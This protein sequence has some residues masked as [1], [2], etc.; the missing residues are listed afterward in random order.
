[1]TED[2][3]RNSAR[4]SRSKLRG[5]VDDE[6]RFHIEQLERDLIARGWRP[7]AAHAEAE[8]R[9]GSMSPIRD[10]CLTIDERRHRRAAWTDTMSA[11]SQDIRYVARTLRKTPAFSFIVTLT[12]ALGIGTATA[13]FSLV[14]GVILKPLPY[15]SPEN[16]VVLFDAQRDQ[17]ELPMS[18][19]EF[20]DW[21]D[22]STQV[23][24]GIGAWNTQGQ[25]L[26]GNGDAEQLLGVRMTAS[27]PELLGVTPLIGRSFRADE[28]PR[29]AAHVVM[30]GE[31]LWRRRFNADAAIVGRTI[32]LT[33]D[34]Y[35]VIGI[36][37]ATARAL[38]PSRW[39][40]GRGEPPDFWMP[41]GLDA[42]NS[43]AGLHN[44][45]VIGR[46]RPDIPLAQASARL[47]DLSEV[48]KKERGTTHGINVVSLTKNLVGNMREPLAL[49]LGAVGVLL[50]I[51]C[52]NVANLMLARAAVRRRELAVRSAL[53]AGR[54]RILILILAESVIRALIG[55]L[56]GTGLAYAMVAVARQS[57]VGIV[58][59]VSEV[60]VDGR[61]LLA[62]LSI[63]LTAGLLFGVVPAIRAA[64]GDLLQG[65]RDGGRGV[66]GSVSRDRI[67]RALIVAEVA[68]S[69]MLLAT[70]GLLT[71]S[72]VNLLSVPTGFDAHNVVV[73]RTWLPSSRYPD[74]LSQVAFW[75]RLSAALEQ[76]GASEVTTASD[77]PIA[78]GTSGDTPMEGTTYAPGE[79]PTAQKRIV[80]SNYFALLRAHIALGRGLQSTDVLGAPPVV[81]VNQ[82]F[83]NRYLNGENP[84]GR[85]A[86]FGWGIDGFQTIVGVVADVR[87]GALN[88]A[89]QPAIYISSEQRPSDFMNVLIRTTRSDA[90]VAVMFRRVLA[91]LDPQLPLM[92][93]RRMSDVMASTVRQQRLATMI[94]GA[95]ALAALVLAA[96][97]LYGVISYSVAQRS[98]E[99]GVRAALGAAR[100]DLMRLVLEQSLGFATAGIA[101][102][103]AG[104]IGAGRLLT[105][106][107]FGVGSSDPLVLGG[108]AAVLIVVAIVASARP[109]LLA[110]KANPLEALRSD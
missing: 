93:V 33:G 74:S 40:L 97:G 102:G 108:V 59:R 66:M 95:F 3:W 10:A 44:L 100:W 4:P 85:R 29:G 105:N 11:I 83:V 67:R 92:D 22:R 61:A 104:S 36:I 15:S 87:E 75:R 25:V 49:L 8:R 68:L 101:I 98:Q 89:P 43:P 64:G 82:A 71:R 80:G 13:I 47:G 76:N 79:E 39:L 41:L 6:L 81:M 52:A 73:G 99:L 27:I 58:P 53:G 14:D 20:L 32:T 23:L 31:R 12:L 7:D 24:S 19:P 17:R 88:G 63:S 16:L 72:F 62:A 110:T 35:T 77:L 48:R 91:Q 94:L 78:G 69:F 1:M 18:Y 106:Q 51:T 9:F 70:A 38:V 65:L 54:E 45:D 21:K 28:E 103:L 57:L 107:L 109:T 46:V 26:S 84:I 90:D 30:L 5:E 56:C 55:G 34:P 2:R 50:L 96:V 60:T 42:Q 86:Q 37:P